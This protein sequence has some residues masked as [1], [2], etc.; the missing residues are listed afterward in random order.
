MENLL[1]DK[2]DILKSAAMN[3][4]YVQENLV[5]GYLKRLE[6]V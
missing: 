2:D 3:R 1:K 5:T 4:L 6:S